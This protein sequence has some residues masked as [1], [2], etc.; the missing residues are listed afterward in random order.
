MPERQEEIRREVL[1]RLDQI[2][3]PCSV[4]GGTPMGLDEM[5]LVKSV[6]VSADGDVEIDLRL[7]SPFCHMIGFMK[8]TAI[9]KA[10]SIEGVRAVE[11]NGDTGLEWTPSMIAPAAEKRRRDRLEDA[12]RRLPLQPQHG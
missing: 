3:D 12:S 6:D 4:A 9:E 5:G 10:S 2:Q 7:T 1:R 8:K 11:V